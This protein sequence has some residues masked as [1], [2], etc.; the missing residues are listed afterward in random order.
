MLIDRISSNFE[1]LFEVYGFVPSKNEEENNDWVLVLTFDFIRLRFVEDRA[2]LFLDIGLI[3]EP[4]VWHELS[5]VMALI[6]ERQGIED[7]IRVSN[8]DKS[9]KMLLRKH[10]EHLILL[11]KDND[12]RK[13]IS[14]LKSI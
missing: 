4:D 10:V 11:A 9:L 6:N 2:D 3:T 7:D 13:T 14:L 1:F 12:F 8:T 5:P